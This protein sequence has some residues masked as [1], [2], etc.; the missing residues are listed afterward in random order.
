MGYDKKANCDVELTVDALENAGPEHEFYIFTGDGDFEFLI[1]KLMEK[2]TKTTIVSH[3]KVY[4]RA[5]LPYGRYSTKLRELVA[6]NQSMLNFQEID[7]WKNKIRKEI[8]S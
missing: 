1:R 7:N 4:K 2:G 5:G 6:A 3:A 8:A